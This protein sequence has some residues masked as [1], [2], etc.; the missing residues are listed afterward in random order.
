MRAA[1][2]DAFHLSFKNVEATGKRFLSAICMSDPENPHVNGAPSITALEAAAAMALVTRR[3]EKKCDIV[4]FSGIQSTEH[5]NITN[6]SISPEACEDDLDAVLD[7]C[8]KLP[9]AKTNNTCL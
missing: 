3:S 7:K 8:S 5:P 4:A 1:M 6:F 9:C 2:R